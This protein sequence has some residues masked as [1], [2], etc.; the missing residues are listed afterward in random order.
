M[1]Q[2]VFGPGDFERLRHDIWHTTLESAAILLCEPDK[3]GEDWR[4]AVREMHV[5]PDDQYEVRTAVSIRL[6]PTFGLPIE[7]KASLKGWSLV[8][9]HTHPHQTASATFSP[10]D[11]NAEVALAEYANRRS[12]S[13]PHCA[14][15]F[16]KESHAAR[17]LGSQEIVTVGQ[18]DAGT[19]YDRQIR[20]FGSDGQVK[21][22]R[23]RVAVVGTGGTGSVV[24]QQLAYLGVRNFLLIDP[25][26]VERTNL[27]RTVGAT[28]RD[29]GNAKVAVAQR[30]IH[31]LR[32]DATVQSLVADVVDEAIA[33]ELTAVD[34]I[35]CCT[36]SHASRHLINQVSYQYGIPAIDMGVAI[37]ATGAAVRF[38]GHV[39]GLTAQEPC[40]W[41]LG[42]LDSRQVREEM[43][44]V[45]QEKADP[46]FLGRSGVVQ[47]A[48][49]SINS[50]VASAA[51]T[52]FLSIITGLDAPARYLVY[53]GNRQR[54][55][56]VVAQKDP[57]C[58]F[59]GPNSAAGAGDT[60]PLPVRRNG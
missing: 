16:A 56:S 53:D 29:I 31:S 51:V 9:C 52:M 43:M 55:A 4:L 59:C 32:P 19:D 12:P 14:L 6:N 46:Y 11:D 40:L 42:Q 45:E 21:L 8:Y 37:D 54:L 3:L 1:I 7:K 34:F 49:I 35:F 5:V 48:V 33:K 2:L 36:D 18:D 17:V 50:T 47:P 10:V 15:L 41:C 28:P 39:K 24:T 26:T 57:N 44:T 22:E 13:V 30:L 27:N 23:L 60:Q 20:A 38:A 25:D 58:V